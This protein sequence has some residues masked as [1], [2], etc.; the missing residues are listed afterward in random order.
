MLFCVFSIV[1]SP[2]AI[3]QVTSGKVT[4]DPGR[5]KGSISVESFNRILTEAPQSVYLMDASS[6]REFAAGSIK[7]ATN[8]PLN[9]IDDRLSS[10]PNDKPIIFFCATGSRA[11]E[12]YETV[13][14]LRKDIQVHFLDAQ[15][16]IRADGSVL[17]R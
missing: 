10:L 5:T 12:A 14:E 8:L 3:A 1:V 6:A 4:I 16:Q 11:G 9:K 7:G 13:K 2:I 17:I 15:V